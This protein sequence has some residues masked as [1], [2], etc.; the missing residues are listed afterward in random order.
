MQR[1]DGGYAGKI[2]EAR[3]RARN[4]T[5]ILGSAVQLFAAKGFEGT[6]LSE[7]ADHCGLPRANLYY[8]FSS[9]DRIYTALIEQVIDG[10]DGVFEHIRPDREPREA[11]EAY[12]KAKLE[13]SR[14]YPVE[15][16]F[17]ASE[18]L[19]GAGFLT[20]RHRQHM[21][22]VTDRKAE[23]VREWVKLGKL[24]P[25]DPYHFFIVLWSA[26]Q[27]YADY[28]HLAAGIIHRKRLTR[29]DFAVAAATISGLVL[30]GCSTDQASATRV[31]V[32]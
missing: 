12:V 21:R 17:F 15:S 3:I 13:Y 5:R 16:R 2:S 23:V 18:I 10:W 19:R 27:F 32:S 25:V 30:D 28:G 7:I 20:R 31:N 8:Y 14:S 9:K 26:T 22:E 24:S 11:I 29:R 4:K 1:Q 6:R